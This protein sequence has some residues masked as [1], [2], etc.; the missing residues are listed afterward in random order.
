MARTVVPVVPRKAYLKMDR[1]GLL[2]YKI[3]RTELRA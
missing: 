2:L 3:Q 1:R